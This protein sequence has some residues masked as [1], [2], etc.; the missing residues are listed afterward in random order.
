M[1]I[2]VT[3]VCTICWKTS[4]SLLITSKF[5]KSICAFLPSTVTY[6][7]S[8]LKI[9]G[10]ESSPNISCNISMRHSLKCILSIFVGKTLGG[11]SII[12]ACN[13]AVKTESAYISFTGVAIHSIIT[14]FPSI[15][16]SIFLKT[17]NFLSSI[18]S[19][20]PAICVRRC[21][22][23]GNEAEKFGVSMANVPITLAVFSPL[24]YNSTAT[25]LDHLHILFVKQLL[26][27][28]FHSVHHVQVLHAVVS[29]YFVG[30]FCPDIVVISSGSDKIVFAIHQDSNNSLDKP[31]CI[32]P[33]D[34]ITTQGPMS[35]K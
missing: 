33:G 34:A 27:F 19:K 24:K 5:I 6:N 18:T 9:L 14:I 23:T 3:A 25:Y 32:I 7:F 31:L 4:S 10:T 29:K 15:V 1:E 28:P 26:I 30:S 13:I 2:F 20:L 17:L 21:F 11:C 22:N 16:T 35:S 12:S 8:P